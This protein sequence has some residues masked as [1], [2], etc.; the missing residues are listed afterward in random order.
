MIEECFHRERFIDAESIGHETVALYS[1]C[2]C[3]HAVNRVLQYLER[4]EYE[5]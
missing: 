5:M 3:C 4:K 2:I 1:E